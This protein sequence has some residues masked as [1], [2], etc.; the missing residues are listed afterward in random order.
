M[1]AER[2]IRGLPYNQWMENNSDDSPL[3]VEIVEWDGT[4]SLQ[5]V[6][7][8]L[9]LAAG[10]GISTANDSKYQAGIMGNVLGTALTK[11]R[12]IH[13]GVIGKYTILTSDASELPKA[14]VIG[15][16]AGTSCD[17][18]VVALLSDGDEL[19]VTPTAAFKVMSM[20]GAGSSFDYGLD[21]FNAAVGEFSAVS[22]GTADIRFSSGGLF[23]TLTTAITA[24]TTTTTYAA[25]TLGKTTNATGRASLFVS[26]GSKWQFLTNS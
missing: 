22:Y 12:N 20:A 23:V 7:G 15:E 26:D 14:G 2:R 25:G 5:A 24:N 18:A 10:A 9:N 21:L 16:A 1:G 13:A 8:D 17:G 4:D 3:F 11:T 6:A 19:N